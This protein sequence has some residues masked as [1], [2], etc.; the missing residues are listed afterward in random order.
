[1]TKKFIIIICIVIFVSC[2][3]TCKEDV[4]FKKYYFSMIDNISLYGKQFDT[5]S[6]VIF[7]DDEFSKFS[8][9]S[10]YLSLLTNH[11]FRYTI[12]EQ[13][14][15]LKHSDL[16]ADIRDLKMWYEKNKCGMTVRISDSIVNGNLKKIVNCR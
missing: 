14:I 10:D 6:V 12:I 3:K 7:N 13:P 9:Y 8:K 2:K 16:E 11:K 1:M 4:T 5:D 15:Y